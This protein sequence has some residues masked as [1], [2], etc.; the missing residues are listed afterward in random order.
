MPNI[1][2]A[3]VGR[4]FF[5]RNG[6]APLFKVFDFVFAALEIP[7]R[8]APRGDDAEIRRKRFDRKF[9]A[10][11][12]IALSRRA[13]TDRT[14]FFLPSVFDENFPDKRSSRRRAEQIPV[15]VERTAFQRRPNIFF[16]IFFSCIDDIACRSARFDR[17]RFYRFPIIALS[18]IDADGDDVVIV[19]FL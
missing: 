12:V 3:A 10:D 9:E 6:N 13:V 16:D 19:I 18:Q 8:I 17:A 1:F 11:L 7:L 2:V 4:R 14:G 15:F 5:Y